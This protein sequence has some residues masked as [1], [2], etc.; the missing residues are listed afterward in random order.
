MKERRT[1]VELTVDEV[2]DSPHIFI[3]SHD[4]FVE[5][6]TELRDALGISSFLVGDL[7]ELGP[8]VERLP[9]RLS[10]RDGWADGRSVLQQLPLVLLQLHDDR[11]GH[12]VDATGAVDG[13]QLLALPVVLDHRQGLGVVDLEPVLDDLLGVVGAAAAGEQ[14]ADQLVPGTS[15]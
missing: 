4:R 10:R 8:V 1:G 5:K 11:P 14:P 2:I 6:F 9:V 3:G 13:D 12:L 15:R 7:D